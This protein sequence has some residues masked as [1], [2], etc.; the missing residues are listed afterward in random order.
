MIT[1]IYQI[2]PEDQVKELEWLRE[3]KIFPAVSSYHDW[4][5]NKP[6]IKIGVIVAPQAALAI[7]LRH[8]LDI[9]VNYKQR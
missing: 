3:Q 1:I 2:N 8:K 4:I 6:T 9:Q 7:K 5:A